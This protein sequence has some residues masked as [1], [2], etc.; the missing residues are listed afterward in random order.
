MTSVGTQLRQAREQLK[1]SQAEVTKDTKI[2]TW[3]LEAIEEDRLQTLM[4]PI[5]VK[6][7]L[8]SYARYLR[9]EP[10]PLIAQLTWPTATSSQQYT[11]PPPAAAPSFSV[12]QLWSWPLARHLAAAA[13]LSL[14]LVVAVM[15]VK[16]AQR[17]VAK[18]PMPKVG[19]ARLASLTSGDRPVK[20]PE[21]PTLTLLAT[22]PLELDLTAHR[23]TWVTVRADG[24]LLAQQ[25]LVRGAQEHWSAKKELELIVTQPSDVELT[26]NGQSISP[27]AM[28]HRGRLLITHR[29]V[30]QLR[31]DLR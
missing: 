11:L 18:L 25:R 13:A 15:A 31:S 14:V 3:V 8:S 2:Q 20:P 22:Q 27:F 23:T 30:T 10:E 1:L 24:R 16:P 17:W 12:A 6:G 29:G 4:S 7:F 26:L 28:A 9:L 5:Y 19:R 21:L